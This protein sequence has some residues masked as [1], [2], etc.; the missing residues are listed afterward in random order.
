[1]GFSQRSLF[2]S[3]T[4][5]PLI[6]ASCLHAST[7]RLRLIYVDEDDSGLAATPGSTKRAAVFTSPIDPAD[8]DRPERQCVRSRDI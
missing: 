2:T 4:L 1:M 7:N 5:L 8:V 6:F 3:A